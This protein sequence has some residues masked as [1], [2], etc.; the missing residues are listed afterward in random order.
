MKT[1]ILNHKETQVSDHDYN[2]ILKVYAIREMVSL[3]DN[4]H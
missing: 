2:E 1:I 3:Q 4:K